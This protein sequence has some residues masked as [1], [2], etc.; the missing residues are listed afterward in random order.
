M[1][2]QISKKMKSELWGVHSELRNSDFTILTLYLAVQIFIS[3]NY[4][5]NLNSDIYIYNYEKKKS[6][7]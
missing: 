4:N 2:S 6:E 5:K 3:H 7:M 1:K